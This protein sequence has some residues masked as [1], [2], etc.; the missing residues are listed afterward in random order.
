MFSYL[1]TIAL[2][3]RFVFLANAEAPPPPLSGHPGSADVQDEVVSGRGQVQ[4][5]GIGRI[6]GDVRVTPSAIDFE[7]RGVGGGGTM[8]QP[9]YC[10]SGTIMVLSRVAMVSSVMAPSLDLLV[11]DRGPIASKSGVRPDLLPVIIFC[12]LESS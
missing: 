7:G 6:D 1:P 4:H 10:D 2:V 3:I 5:S 8:I 9:M 11:I 12:T